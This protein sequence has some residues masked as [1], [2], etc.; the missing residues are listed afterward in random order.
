MDVSVPGVVALWRRHSFNQ[1]LRLGWKGF[2]M[3][4][5]PG[6]Q[7][8]LVRVGRDWAAKGWLVATVQS[9]AGDDGTGGRDQGQLGRGFVSGQKQG[10]VSSSFSMHI[11]F[12]PGSSLLPSSPPSGPPHCHGDME[13]SSCSQCAWKGPFMFCSFIPSPSEV[14]TVIESGD[15]ISKAQRWKAIYQKQPGQEVN[16]V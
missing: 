9:T 12:S 2:D 4:Q 14:A 5:D 10:V 7:K 15:D 6:E 13:S 3:Q 1:T 8:S 16:R 11:P